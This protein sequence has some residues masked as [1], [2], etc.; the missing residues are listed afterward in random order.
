MS[1]AIGKKSA[2]NYGLM[3]TGIS[4]KTITGKVPVIPTLHRTQTAPK[5]L[6]R[7]NCLENLS[8]NNIDMSYAVL[9]DET[10]KEVVNYLSE[11]GQPINRP[12]IETVQAALTQVL[13]AAHIGKIPPEK[14]RI[15]LAQSAQQSLQYARWEPQVGLEGYHSNMIGFPRSLKVY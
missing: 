3:R 9:L 13:V 6:K 7:N 1:K 10:M 8:I 2:N 5:Y 12:T 4:K 11:R 15:L 14:L